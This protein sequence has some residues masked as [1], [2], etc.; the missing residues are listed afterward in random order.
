MNR[1]RK[2]IEKIEKALIHCHRKP[3][4]IQESPFWHRR[5]MSRVLAESKAGRVEARRGFK[6]ENTVWRFA[7]AAGL[8]AVLLAAYA[9]DSGLEAQVTLSELILSDS[10]ALDIITDFGIL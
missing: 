3:V 10:P 8:V 9:V 2:D 4:E 1:R 7:F 5:V 6:A